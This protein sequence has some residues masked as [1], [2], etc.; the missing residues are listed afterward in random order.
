MSMQERLPAVR[1]IAEDVFVFSK[2]AHELSAR[3]TVELLRRKTSFF[4]SPELAQISHILDMCFVNAL[5]QHALDT[6]IYRIHIRTVG[7]PNSGLMK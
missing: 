1:S 6:I 3:G 7:W 4:I 2:T 5:L